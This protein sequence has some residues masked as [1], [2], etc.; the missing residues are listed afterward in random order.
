MKNIKRLQKINLQIV[1]GYPLQQLSLVS[2]SLSHQDG[3][4][5]LYFG[6][7]QEPSNR[8]SVFSDLDLF[9]KKANYFLHRSDLVTLTGLTPI[10]YSSFYRNLF[11]NIT[12]YG[13]S[14]IVQFLINIR[15]I[16][17]I[18]NLAFAALD[19][20]NNAAL[21]PKYGVGNRAS[22]I[23]ALKEPQAFVQ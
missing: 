12:F 13:P 21:Q 8:I 23:R 15:M 17:G 9:V 5:R 6:T 1:K 7:C 22:F 3:L 20:A 16:L 19:L 4:E 11:T 18:R 10:L 14:G 2:L